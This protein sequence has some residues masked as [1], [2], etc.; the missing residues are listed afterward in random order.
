MAV[1][2]IPL[3][4]TVPLSLFEEEEFYAVVV[5]EKNDKRD[6]NTIWVFRKGCGT[7]LSSISKIAEKDDPKMTSDGIR[8]MDSMGEFDVV[9]EMLME[10]R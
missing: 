1:S 2:K 5:N 9:K 8:T 4:T 10:E 3:A 7:A 6:F